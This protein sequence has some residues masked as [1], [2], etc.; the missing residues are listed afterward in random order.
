MNSYKELEW[1]V[2]ITKEYVRGAGGVQPQTV[3]ENV[4]RKL[5]ELAQD[6]E[7]PRA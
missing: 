6:A 2:E 4:Y 3:L 1:A 7:M 5:K